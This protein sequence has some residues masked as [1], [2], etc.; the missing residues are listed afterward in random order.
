MTNYHDLIKEQLTIAANALT[1]A[2]SLSIESAK[3]K[4]LKTGKPYES[5]SNDDVFDAHLRV[6]RAIKDLKHYTK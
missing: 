2:M 3:E 6:I 4:S 1:E 5:E